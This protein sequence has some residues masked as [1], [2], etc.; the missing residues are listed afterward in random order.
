MNVF[1]TGISSGIGAALAE[2][3]VAQGH[4]VWGVAR[5]GDLMAELDGRLG[6][7]LLRFDVA[8]IRNREDIR[9]VATVMHAAGFVPD[10]VVLNAGCYV[11][12]LQEGTYSSDAAANVWKTNLDG[13]LNVV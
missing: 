8:D 10:A 5:R 12:D 13:A 7:P 4:A 6:S 2:L 11:P 1:I 3:L 9:R